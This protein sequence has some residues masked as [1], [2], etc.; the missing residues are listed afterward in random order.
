[1]V[2]IAYWKEV[3]TAFFLFATAR[4]QAEIYIQKYIQNGLMD[5][6]FKLTK[7]KDV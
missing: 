6:T 7:L 5:E 2:H 3:T 1:M 4:K